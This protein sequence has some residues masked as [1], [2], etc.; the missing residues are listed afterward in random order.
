[1]KIILPPNYYTLICYCNVSYDF[2]FI[3]LLVKLRPTLLRNS[4]ENDLIEKKTPTYLKKFFISIFLGTG[5]NASYLEDTKK[6]IYGMQNADEDYLHS[7]MIIDTEWGGFGD[8]NEA[9]YIITQYDKI[10]DKRSDHPGVN[11]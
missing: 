6:L 3:F 10:I 5:T 1:M 9:E 11:T 4:N 7:Q 8:R 2:S